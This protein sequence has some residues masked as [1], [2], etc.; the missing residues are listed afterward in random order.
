MKKL[1]T[2][3]VAV[4]ALA[5]CAPKQPA[6]VAE[7]EYPFQNPALPID[8]RVE[9]IIS[10][11]TLEEKA[12]LL[13]DGTISIDRLGI[14][15]YFWWS[16]AC[17]GITGDGVT[18]FPQSIGL[19]ASFDEAQQLEI[20]KAVSDEA[21]AKWNMT[22]PVF[23]KTH[24]NC[25]GW[26]HGL[27]FWCPNVNIFRDPRWGRGQETCGEDPFLAGVMGTATVKGM[28]GDDP[29]YFKTIACGKHFAVHSGPESKR[30]IFD[31]HVSARDLWETYLPAFRMLVKDGHVQQVMG[32]YQRFEGV[33]CNAS[34]KLLGEILR[35]KW[36]YDGVVVSDCGAIDNF[37]VKG[38]HETHPDA[39]SASAAAILAGC[40]IECGDNFQDYLPEAVKRG[41]L[42]E[43]DINCTLRRTFRELF[44][45]GIFDPA[46]G[47]PW[48]DFG[49]E[50]IS[51]EKNAEIAHEAA[52][53]TMVL[54]KNEGAV[55]PLKAGLK[56]I[57]VV[58]PNADNTYMQLG[59]YSG[60][61][62]DEHTLS[63]VDAIR[64]QAGDA[65]VFYCKACN[66][67]TEETEGNVD[68]AQLSADVADSDV[69]IVV[70][71]L[72]ASLEGEEMEVPYEGFCGG[73]RTRIELPSIQQDLVK[74]MHA[75][76]KPV[77]V[78]NCSGS[79][80]AFGGIEDQYDA[81][82]QAW[83]GGQAAGLAVA[84][85]LF[86][87]YNPAGRLPLTF[88]ASTDQL[89]DF[90]DYGMKG[91]TY[92]YF[93]GKPLYAFGYG[94]SY[95]TFEYGKAKV[96]GAKHVITIPV[97]NTGSVDGDEVVQVYIKALDDPDAPIKTLKGF[98]R[99]NIPAGAT[100]KVKIE[101]GDRAF[102]YYDAAAD[103]LSVKSGRY[104]I[105]YG[106]SSND[107]DL[108]SISLTI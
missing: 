93:E 53:K 106:S 23:N 92:R 40:D 98:K 12:G 1:A 41:L 65:E 54:L 24:A 45:L 67:V 57:A 39:A 20:Y 97:T 103:D 46:E 5:S 19:A 13:Q 91:K 87:K 102:E 44:K 77:V 58:G 66:H 11:L 33:P 62:T 55:L 86:G 81:L 108:Q 47:N 71:G 14:P 104:E 96:K 107:E 10:L 72:T 8:E 38:R 75:T 25:N 85:V 82:V 83:Y 95:T 94:L 100:V 78:V 48:K 74:A 60:T 18:V 68:L 80:I 70:T 36:N 49:P 50:V 89:G 88:Y 84:D 56:K 32:A 31:A 6:T 63:I 3:A 101:L 99:V 17:H 105:L 52:R 34:D 90:E 35:G 29:K 76:G 69:I 2:I 4:L 22:E 79:A 26:S 61:P 15:A 16:E 28:Q 59:N 30:H 7:Y 64:K 42:T 51:S 37:Y 43:E 21:R 27:S 73:D 9:N